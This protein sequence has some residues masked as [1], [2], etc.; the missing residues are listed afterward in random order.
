MYPS[1][2]QMNQARA[3][4][5]LLSLLRLQLFTL[6][7]DIEALAPNWCELTAS[8][9]E[10]ITSEALL[11]LRMRLMHATTLCAPQPPLILCITS[12][13]SSEETHTDNKQ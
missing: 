4:I 6:L 10:N 5:L 9:R 1:E 7:P 8:C 13:S 11:L 2:F 3:I 12:T